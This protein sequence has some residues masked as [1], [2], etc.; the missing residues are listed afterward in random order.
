MRPLRPPLAA[1][2][3]R[4]TSTCFIVRE[5][6]RL[7]RFVFWCGHGLHRPNVGPRVT[8]LLSGNLV[9]R[10]LVGVV[11]FLLDA[12]A[13]YLVEKN[14]GIVVPYRD[15]AEHLQLFVPHVAAFFSNA[16]RYVG[17]NVSITIVQ[18]EYGLEFNR[19]FMNNIGYSL[20]KNE[21]D[22]ICFHDV[23]YM[24]IQADYSEPNGFAPIAWYGFERRTDPRNFTFIE[25][26]LEFFFGGVVLFRKNDFEK[27]N[28][29]A[30]AYWG[31][32]WE[33]SDIFNRCILE[34]V[35]LTRR[36]GTF[37]VLPHMH[38]G[39]D[40]S[41]ETIVGS[42]AHRRNNELFR[43]RFPFPA[44]FH[45]SKSEIDVNRQTCMKENDGL[46]TIEFSILDRKPIPRPTTDERGLKIEIV[47]V[48][49]RRPK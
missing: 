25:D 29:F 19:G 6:H 44:R 21:C 36:K 27:V 42:V 11:E 2:F 16:A 31:W 34:E 46:S 41:G 9:S 35:S 12:E 20:S 43:K 45:P 17:G 26:N 7:L 23:D 32:G 28:G 5:D 8:G 38:M 22:Y 4:G 33:D 47:T 18:Q 39:Y 48:S 30:N 37:K 40:I 1:L 15:R 10:Y 13:S 14:L 3:G 49:V 24:P